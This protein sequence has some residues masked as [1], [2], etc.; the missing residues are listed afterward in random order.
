MEDQEFWKII[1]AAR[2]AA[3]SDVYAR[4]MALGHELEPLSLE[5]IQAFQVKYDEMIHRTNRWDLVG[6]ATIMNDGCTDDGF[7][8]FCHRLVSEGQEVFERAL[9]DPD[10]LADLPPTEYFDLESFSYVALKVFA[11]KGGGTLV[12]DSSIESA[13]LMGEDWEDEDLPSLLPR[14]VEMYGR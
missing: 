6:A 5:A 14:L 11:S 12:R 1:D 8:Y 10:N 9:A 4:I 13:T 7:R 2:D 3:G